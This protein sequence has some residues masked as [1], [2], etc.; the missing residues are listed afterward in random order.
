MLDSLGSKLRKKSL[1]ALCKI[2]GRQALLPKSVQI[3]LSYDR[4]DD[5][6]YS[7]GYADVWMGEHQ[8]SKVAVKVL[9]VYTTSN[10]NKITSVGYPLNFLMVHTRVLITMAQ[11]FCREVMT[12]KSLRHPN[13]LPLLGVK[14]GGRHFAMVSEWMDNGSINDFIQAN[15][16]ADRFKLVGHQ[17]SFV[18]HPALTYALLQL[19]GVTRGLIY[20]HSQG[21]IHGDLKGV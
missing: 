19:K 18:A 16:D 4:S 8:G 6:L 12:W 17:S 3:P 15:P 2:C 21:M 14:M 9:R 11:R 20:M 7:G 5:A 10:L 1:S 13:V